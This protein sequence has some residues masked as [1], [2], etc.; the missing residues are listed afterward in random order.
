MWVDFFETPFGENIANFGYP[1][2]INFCDINSCDINF[3]DINFCEL[4]QN[5]QKL[6]S[7]KRFKIGHSQ[8]LMSQKIFKSKKVRH[9]FFSDMFQALWSIKLYYYLLNSQEKYTMKNGEC[10]I[11]ILHKSDIII[12]PSHSQK[13]MSQNLSELDNRKN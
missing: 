6:M 11:V 13:L 12:I 2:T 10:V 1:K 9:K 4:C 7:Q 5:S 3:C 8:K